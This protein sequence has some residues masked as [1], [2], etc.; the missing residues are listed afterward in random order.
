MRS[1]RLLPAVVAPTVAVGF[2]LLLS[3]GVLLLIG[4]S[5]VTAFGAMFR[6]A[7]RVDSAISI[8]NRAVPLYLS[9]LAVGL[10]FKMGLF[11][12][13]V[14]GQ[15]RLA[16]LV[17]AWVGGTVT[18]LPAPLHVALIIVTAMA[19][20]AGWAGIAGVLKVTRGVHE[21]ISTIML[22]F[23]GTGL[24]AY[25]LA[26][27]FR[28]PP[29]PGDLVIKTPDI[30]AS[31]QMPSLNP[32][33][34]ALGVEVPGGSDLQG[35]LIL[36]VL[37]GVIFYL[38]IWRTRFGYDLR[39]SGIS[40]TA[41]AASGVNPKRMILATMVLSGATAGLVGMPMLLGFFHRYTI[42]FPIMLGF[43]GIAVALLGRNHPVGVA[44]AALLFGFLD[45]SSQILDFE[46][47]PKEIVTIVQGVI[48]L[49]VVVAYEVTHRI[50]QRRQ[51][52]EVAAELEEA[53]E[54][55]EVAP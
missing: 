46:A 28:E 3:G 22:N 2:A 49:S 50:V 27:Y 47:I 35:F 1:S 33:L 26:A 5:P 20:G 23:I 10:G 25:L 19:V 48:I 16:A 15:Y 42:D 41:A 31:G 32:I 8:V 34:E 43:T 44:L 21:V 29:E 7:A 38:L 18:G 13:G 51:A 39:A 54:A 40:A 11:N 37:A 55:E 52:E 30:P 6:F 36:A 9:A 4:E 24:G 53:P 12:I 17:A 45:R 14:E